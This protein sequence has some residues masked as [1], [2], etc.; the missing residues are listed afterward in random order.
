LSISF[1]VD[2]DLEIIFHIIKSSTTRGIGQ[3]HPRGRSR[4]TCMQDRQA[5]ATLCKKNAP[6]AR[7]FLATFS[8]SFFV[9]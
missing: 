4:R 7:A 2:A 5:P 9:R 1:E 6:I 8:A 3:S